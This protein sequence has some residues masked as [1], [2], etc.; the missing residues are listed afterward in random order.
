MA[1][2]AADAKLGRDTVVLAMG[3]FLGVTDAFV[4]TSGANGRQVR[5]IVDEVERQV[6]ES[7]GPVAA[8]H[9]GPARPDLGAHGLRRLPRPRL[10]GRGAR[11]LR[12]R[13]VVGQRASSLVPTGPSTP[14]RT[15]RR[16]R[17]DRARRRRRFTGPTAAN[18]AVVATGTCA[19]LAT[20]TSTGWPV[21]LEGDPGHPGQGRRRE[22]DLRHRLDLG[23]SHESGRRCRP[24]S[25]WPCRRRCWRRGR[26]SGS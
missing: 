10:P 4:I 21:E 3:D 17:T 24:G 22:H 12:P 15:E 23:G 5:T 9:R 1:A 25:P 18:C 20:G 6:K 7:R 13:T 16:R 11:L 26:W 8:C 14:P 2:R 19:P